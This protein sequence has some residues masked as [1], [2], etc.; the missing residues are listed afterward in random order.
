MATPLAQAF[1]RIRPDTSTFRKDTEAGIAKAGRGVTKEGRRQGALFG[2]SFGKLAGVAAGA[3]LLK[4]GA[5]A[6]GEARDA[7]K[8][9]RLTAQVIKSTGGAAK[10]SAG[11]VAKLSEAISNQTGIDDDAI[12]ANANLLL[13]F[14]NI[15]N[16]VGKGN[17][18]FNQATR[19]VQ[20]MSAALGQDG[21]ASAIQLG[22]ALNDPIKGVTALQRVGVSFT[23]AQRKQIAA[24]VGSGKTLEAQK[25]ILAELGK[26]FGGAAAA[27]ADPTK[28]T[29][30]AIDN[31]KESIGTALVPVMN[32]AAV[33][34]SGTLIPGLRSFGEFIS[35][36]RD[37]ILPLVT[38]LGTFVATLYSAVKVVGLLNVALRAMGISTTI[39]LGPVGL[40][41]AGI[42]ALAAGLIYAYKHSETFRRIVDT[43]FRVVKAAATAVLNFFKKNWPLIVGFLLG[44]IGI[45]TALIIKNSQRIKDGAT[46]VKTWI[47]DRFNG[48]LSFFKGLPGKIARAAAGMWDGIKDAFRAAINWIIN[49]WNN[50]EFKIPGFDPPGPGPKFSGFTLGLP[51]VPLLD[52]G[53]WLP[54]G[55]TLAMNNTGRP[56]RVLSPR[57]SAG[58]V[59]YG[60][61]IVNV[62]VGANSHEIGREIVR[63]IKSYEQGSGKAWRR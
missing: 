43:A 37:V 3:G 9:G 18:I 49:A 58:N 32:R 35:R 40:I 6:F 11:Q 15:R 39:A 1:V 24:L 12:Q 41:I 33:F 26:E 17:D 54:P 28:K 13:T 50:L 45:A 16:E 48:L 55:L 4:L 2:A 62:P 31:L 19:V 25:V 5:D 53:G 21:K 60:P 44:P 20:D 51:N 34:L 8:I 59:Q 57:E 52:S 56:E 30:V 38:V 10:I 7:A 46:A 47:V 14:T 36:N 23:K 27:A 29:A 61:I 63:H 42:A 22:K